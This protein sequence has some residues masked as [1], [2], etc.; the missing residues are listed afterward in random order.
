MSRVNVTEE[1]LELTAIDKATGTI[2]QVQGAYN[3]L[4]SA[5]S[6][7]KNM[8]GAIGV[9]VGAGAL[10]SL[11]HDAM[12]SAAALDDM[13][14]ST[15]VSVENLSKLQTVA[16]IGG[17]DFEGLTGQIS[18]MIKGLKGADE[19]G[20]NAGRAMQFLNVQAKDGTGRFRDTGDILVDVARKLS[21]YEDGAN[22]VALVQDLLGKGAERYIPFL[23]DLAEETGVHARLTAQQAAEAERAEK[24]INRLKLAMEDARRELVVHLTPALSDFLERLMAA[25]EAAG[26][27]GPGLFTMGITSTANI[28]AELRRLK[29]ERAAM[30]NRDWVSGNRSRAERMGSEVGRGLIGADVSR[31]SWQIEYLEGLKRRRDVAAA[32][33]GAGDPNSPLFEFGGQPLSYESKGREQKGLSPYEGAALQLRGQAARAQFADNEY[34]NTQLEIQAG[35]Y[36]KLTEAQRQHLLQLA[37]QREVQKSLAE[38]RKEELEGRDAAAK[39]IAAYNEQL[40]AQ[41][42]QYRDLLDPGREYLRDQEK[43]N[44][45]VRHGNITQ[46]EAYQIQRK[47]FEA[48][49]QAK[50]LGDSINYAATASQA[51]GLAFTSAMDQ[52]VM[53]SGRGIRAADVLK[54]TLLDVAK[55]L[56]GKF[57]TQP[58][59]RFFEQLI[60]GTLQGVANSY[61]GGYSGGT[62][63]TTG[64]EYGTWLHSGGIA[65]VDGRRAYVHAATFENAPRYHSGL[66]PDEIPAVLRKGEGVF[67]PAQMKALGGTRFGPFYIDARGADRD[68]L[69]Q[70]ARAIRRLDGSIEERAVAAAF[71]TMRRGARP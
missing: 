5:M 9:T 10:I 29:A 12:K 25:R 21:H 18:K 32:R 71:D 36:G 52:L 16:K 70:L 37:A 8:L 15:G 44:G 14:E 67:T 68:G 53:S 45:L 20:Q 7:V 65:G 41:A 38:Q 31:V 33:A 59:G 30:E 48:R 6:T 4:G 11:Y 58:A 27:F 17:H 42:E 34:I 24:N 66:M 43:L 39:A 50:D 13:A 47:L 1:R 2:K 60:M 22:K 23:K 69:A 64:G 62:G 51:F 26:G 57:V 35:K 55:L 63:M 28:D 61:G 46:E 19:E 54:A 40:R 56:Y 49:H 3:Q